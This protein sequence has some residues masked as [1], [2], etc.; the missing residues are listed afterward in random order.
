MR[1]LTNIVAQAVKA[2]HNNEKFAVPLLSVKASKAADQNPTDASLVTASNVLKGMVKSEKLFITRAELNKLCEELYSP[3][4]K[5]L[6]LFAEELDRPELQGP[7]KYN[8]DPNEGIA[9]KEDYARLADPILANALSV[10]FESEHGGELKLYSDEMGKKA[11][12]ACL[13]KLNLIGVPPKKVSVFAGQPNLIVCQ[14]TYETPK[15]ESNVLVPVEINNKFALLPTAFMND[16]GDT[17]GLEQDSLESYIESTAGQS[18]RIKNAG[19]SNAFYKNAEALEVPEIAMAP[20]HLSLEQRMSSPRGV[21]EFEFGAETVRNATDMLHR[22]LAEFGYKSAQVSVVGSDDKSIH[23]AVAVGPMTG[24]RVPVNVVGGVVQPVTVA[25]AS[26]Q[27]AEFSKVGVD[28]LCTSDQVDTRMLAAASPCYEMK[29]AEL[30]DEV[31][32]AL[33]ENNLARAEDAINVLAESDAHNY[34]VALDIFMNYLSAK[35]VEKTASAKGCSRIVKNSTS[36]QP[37]CGH[38]NLPLNKVWQDENGDCQPMHR[39]AM[40][41]VGDPAIFMASKILLG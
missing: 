31:K 36:S 29:P 13:N 38:L 33:S 4:T 14:A 12:S 26:G 16:K 5:L 25:I 8:R 10:I 23:Y 24:F 3:N 15:G 18:L 17:V 9:I 40:Q 19:L 28:S 22:K 6:T 2:L 20:E 39:K 37:I 27:V 11:E 35:P 41:D 1:E 21:A 7:T 32:K 30:L 34:K